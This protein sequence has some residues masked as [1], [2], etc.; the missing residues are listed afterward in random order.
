MPGSVRRN[1]TNTYL[2]EC[3]LRRA[4][5]VYRWW[6]I[7]GTPLR[8]ANGEIQKWLGTCTDIEELKRAEEALQRA[9][10]AAEAANEPR[11][12]SWPI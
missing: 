5:G 3:R 12:S 7:H 1:T 10:E 4:D 11:A 9:K 6:L 8:D 2:L